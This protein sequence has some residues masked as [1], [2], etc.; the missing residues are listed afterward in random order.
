MA[1]YEAFNAARDLMRELQISTLPINP[2]ELARQLSIPIFSYSQAINMGYIK[3][4]KELREAK[5]DGFCCRTPSI[6]DIIIYDETK[7]DRVPFT[8]AHEIGHIRLNHHMNNGI[9]PRYLNNKANDPIEKAADDF[10]GELLRSPFL[11]YLFKSPTVPNIKKHCGISEY[12]AQVGL[13]KLKSLKHNIATIYKD[14]VKFYHIQFY[15]YLYMAH[16]DNCHY[17]F[18]HPSAKYCPLCG[19]NKLDFGK[20]KKPMIYTGIRITQCS[21]CANEEIDINAVFC[22]I[23]GGYILNKCSDSNCNLA[24]T[25]NARFCFKCGKPT[26][27][28]QN[29]YFENW[30]TEKQRKESNPFGS[31]VFPDEEMPF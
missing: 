27:F 17:E 25:S 14:I 23:C 7:G 18:I 9:T 12:A 6:P 8:I 4:V 11:I 21:I 22:K 20:D 19:N 1:N 15:N 2:I 26:A 3:I 29:N 10:A 30:E 24:A 16:C 28:K 13:N 31:E 5:V